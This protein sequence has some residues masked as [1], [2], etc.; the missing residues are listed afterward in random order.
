MSSRSTHRSLALGVAAVTVVTG[1]LLGRAVTVQSVN[2]QP[3]IYRAT[4]NN[5]DLDG[6][7]GLAP[8]GK[9]V[10]LWYRQRNFREGTVDGG[11]DPFSWCAWKHGGT[12]ALIGTTRADAKGVFRMSNLRLTS[13]TVSLFPAGP[14]EDKC[15]GGVFTELLPRACDTPGVNCSL[16]AAPKLHWLNVRKTAPLVG[17]TAGAVSLADQAAAAVADGPDTGSQFGDRQDVDQNAI[18][19]TQPGFVPGQHVSWKCGAGGTAVCPTVAIH[20]AST[21][22][23]ADAEY[24]YLLGTIQAHRYGGSIFAAAAIPRGQDLGFTVNVN[25]KFR[26]RLDINLGCDAPLPFLFS[27]KLLF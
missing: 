18:D 25:A 14:K 12:P 22:T 23:E 4:V 8:P 13:T 16:Q 21:I 3:L 2:P 11:P 9:V 19:T 17:A 5:N 20:D 15:L 27:Q 6:V 7:E 10:E 1:A 24:P 26:G